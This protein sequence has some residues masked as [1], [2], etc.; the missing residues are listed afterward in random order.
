MLP[1]PAGLSSGSSLPSLEIHKTSLGRALLQDEGSLMAWDSSMDFQGAQGQEEGQE[2]QQFLKQLGGCPPSSLP[3]PWS[4]WPSF[5][6][7]VLGNIGPR[8]TELC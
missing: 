2:D 1:G 7:W 8:F 5:W 3:S 4:S 6:L